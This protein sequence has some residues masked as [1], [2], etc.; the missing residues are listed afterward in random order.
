MDKSTTQNNSQ[1]IR[2]E[3]EK[4][5]RAF[6][7][8]NLESFKAGLVEDVVAFEI[9]LEGKPVRLG[10][11][12]DVVKYAEDIFAQ[13]KKMGASLKLDIHSIQC[14]ETSMLSYCTAEFDFKAIMADGSTMSQ[15]SRLSVVLC[16]DKDS[17]K[18]MHWHSSLATLPA[19]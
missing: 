1:K 14:H 7:S 16:K 17:W 11:R 9:D 12:N 4:T 3:V 18:W 10:S 8:M 15:P 19:Q 13:V 6:V 5:M 2:E